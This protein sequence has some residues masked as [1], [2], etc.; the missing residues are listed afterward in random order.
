MSNFFAN[1]LSPKKY[2]HKPQAQ[3]TANNTF[4]KK[5]TCKM[6]M[7]LLMNLPSGHQSKSDFGSFLPDRNDHV[8]DGDG[9]L[10]AGPKVGVARA[11]HAHESVFTFGPENRGFFC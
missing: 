11:H 9:L 8:G 2:K 5:A 10:D 7:N 6:L 4:V 3:Q 1:F